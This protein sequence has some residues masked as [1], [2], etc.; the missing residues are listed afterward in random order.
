MLGV[1][2]SGGA[3]VAALIV[4]ALGIRVGWLPRVARRISIDA[5]R[6]IDAE[7][8]R[9][10]HEA[11]QASATALA[12]LVTVA[13]SL[14]LQE[15]IGGHDTY[16]RLFPAAEGGRYWELFGYAWWS[17]W[18]VIGYV[19][20]PAIVIA[21]LPGERLRDFHVSPRGT[22]RHLWIYAALFLAVLPAVAIASTTQAFRDTYP[23]YRLASRSYVDLVAWEALY[24]AQFLSLE[25]FFR[26]F[27]LHGL[28]RA[29]GAN[30]IFVMLVPYCMIHFG[31]PMPETLGAIGAG[32]ILGTLAMRTRSIWGGVLIHV[33][34]ATTMDLLA[35]R[36]C[37]PIGGGPCH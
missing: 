30:A 11:G 35:L 33:G 6:A 29:L 27:I 16:E 34:V 21:C 2:L 10:P 19:I 13:A 5:W 4:I 3:V 31:K 8:P 23:F 15:Y 7:T 25:F 9:L 28:R 14:T 17:G 32:L 1:A 22:L 18:R 37:P 36:G 12:V 26:G 24:A 20:V